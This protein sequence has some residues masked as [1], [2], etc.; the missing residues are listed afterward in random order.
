MLNWDWD[1]FARIEFEGG[2]S[3]KD[4]FIDAWIT[5]FEIAI[6]SWFL[7]IFI[8]IFV[9]TFRTLPANNLLYRTLSMLGNL[10]VDLFRNIPILVQLFLWLYVVPKLIPGLS[11]LIHH[12]FAVAV[13][14]LGVF[15][16]TR[17]AEQITAGIRSIPTGKYHAALSLGLSTSQAYNHVLLP[18]A[19][20]IIMPPMISEAM[21][22]VK[23]TAA[24]VILIGVSSL[25]SFASN[26]AGNNEPDTFQ[27]YMLVTIAFAVTSIIFNLAMRLLER[28]LQLPGFSAAQ[29]AGGK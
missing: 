11:F 4:L 20:R 5:T 17:I 1:F 6:L 2:P 12:Q 14:G 13:L 7:A 16:S 9:G 8:G 27:V 22:I 19:A 28:K 15:T 25:M 29:Q 18:I 26:V 10:W 23:N 24:A 3:Y 21:N